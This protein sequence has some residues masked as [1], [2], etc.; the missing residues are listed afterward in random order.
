M[1]HVKHCLI[2][3]A[4]TLLLLLALGGPAFAYTI[5]VNPGDQLDVSLDGYKGDFMPGLTAIGRTSGELVIS[6][7]K[8]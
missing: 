7:I 6:V 1:K 5:T 3:A 8:Q 2:A 4:A